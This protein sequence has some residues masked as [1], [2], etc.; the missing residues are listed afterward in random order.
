MDA[1]PHMVAHAHDAGT[2][3]GP[4]EREVALLADPNSK[5]CE[6]PGHEGQR[7]AQEDL[8]LAITRNKKR[9]PTSGHSTPRALKRT[10]LLDRAA[11][12]NNGHRMQSPTIRPGID[13]ALRRTISDSEQSA[14]P[15]RT[16][17]IK[18]RTDASSDAGLASKE[19][20][21]HA[22]SSVLNAGSRELPEAPLTATLILQEQLSKS[23]EERAHLQERLQSELRKTDQLERYRRAD[24]DVIRDL[25]QELRKVREQLRTTKH[26]LRV[27]SNTAERLQSVVDSLKH[28]STNVDDTGRRTSL[29]EISTAA[30]SRAAQGP[31]HIA[32][33]APNTARPSVRSLGQSEDGSIV[34]KSVQPSAQREAIS[35]PLSCQVHEE[36]RPAGTNVATTPAPL[37]NIGQPSR[38]V[39]DDASNDKITISQR[40]NGTI[41]FNVDDF[42]ADTVQLP[43]P[44][45]IAAKL[46][47]Q[48]Q[49]WN[50]S[51]TVWNEYKG[52]SVPACIESRIRKRR[53]TWSHGT[54]K[55][56]DFCHSRGFLCVAWVNRS[57]LRLLPLGGQ[58]ANPAGGSTRWVI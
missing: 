18:A 11:L 45:L 44:D 56:C 46:R 54:D 32:D 1:K 23:E 25:E 40:R 30:S 10:Q 17:T 49:R 41:V 34:S 4:S 16:D 26:D 58:A 37:P 42:L 33:T 38:N 57:K 15:R 55:A 47:T 5:G 3:S 31:E 20:S 12:P 2:I 19:P 9:K 35:A 52:T 7:L 53:F 48:I 29:P 21:P 28:D 36:M 14:G 13:P 39:P 43:V 50:A 6:A 27:S 22:R 24:D 8:T 51:V